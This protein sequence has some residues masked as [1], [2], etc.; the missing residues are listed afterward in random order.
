[1]A[2]KT[3]AQ[4]QA[5]TAALPAP[6]TR[7]ALITVLD[8][9]I[10]S[11]ENLVVQYTTVQRDALVTSLGLKIFNT[12][13]AR[14]EI[15]NG[16]TW[17]ACS[18][19][20][21]VAV[22]CSANPNYAEGSVGDQYIVS[23]AGKIGGASGKTVYVGDLVYCIVKNAG[24]TEASVGTSWQVCYSGDAT[25]VPTKYAQISLSSAQ[26]LALDVTPI[27]LVSAPG[28]GKIILPLSMVVNFTYVSA[29]YNAAKV[30]VEYVGASAELKNI[31]PFLN[32]IASNE[33]FFHTFNAESLALVV[34]NAA[35]RVFAPAAITTG[36]GTMTV[37]VYYKIHTL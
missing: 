6:I 32:T 27:N 10:D 1:M 11:Y 14:M 31:T 25:D 20:Q 37:G 35:F 2:V 9:M 23:V 7:T 28:A 21:V 19:K 33:I 3:K 24:G 26:I 17:I 22:D 8:D 29:A 34:S 5:D 12:T 13:N 16:T 4:L 30:A 36:D 18:Q 15:F